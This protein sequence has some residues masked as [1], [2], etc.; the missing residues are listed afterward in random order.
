M[1]PASYSAVTI[2]TRRSLRQEFDHVRTLHRESTGITTVQRT[3]A[4]SHVVGARVSVCR[5]GHWHVARRSGHA[6]GYRNGTGLL[7][8][9]LLALLVKYPCF[10]FG[11]L[12]AS[13]TGNSLVEG[14]R[15]MFG[16]AVVDVFGLIQIPV[17]AIIIAAI[18][19]TTACVGGNFWLGIA[20][21]AALRVLTVTSTPHAIFYKPAP[22]YWPVLAVEMIPRDTRELTPVEL[23]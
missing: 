12:Y 18:A 15:Q 22:S 11:P 7:V 23:V 3:V 19:I 17:F 16:K 2:W 6:R 14:Y 9:V 4:A 13:T 5:C 8:F 1:E 21:A 20:L 10:Y